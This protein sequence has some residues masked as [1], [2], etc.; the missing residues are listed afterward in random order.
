MTGSTIR[1][2]AP[3]S[4]KPSIEKLNRQS[5]EELSKNKVVRVASLVIALPALV[6]GITLIVLAGVGVLPLLPGLLS[7]IVLA[8][9]S[10]F[11]LVSW[12]KSYPRIERDNKNESKIN[13]WFQKQRKKDL[14]KA[15]KNPALFGENIKDASGHSAKSQTE[16]ILKETKDSYLEEIFEANQELLLFMN[17]VP[18][19]M[20]YVDQS[21]ESC[22]RRVISSYKL[23]KA[24]KPKLESLINDTV[25]FGS[26][27]IL[28]LSSQYQEQGKSEC[29]TKTALVSFTLCF[30][31]DA[32]PILLRAGPRSAL[33]CYL[34]LRRKERAENFFNPQHPCYY[35]RLAFN[36]AIGVYRKLFKISALK[37]M[38]HKNQYDRSNN[39]NL[40]AILSFV[41]TID[42]GDNFLIEHR[43]TE[44]IERGNKVA[45]FCS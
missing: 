7:G 31:R 3:E 18:K 35:A 6:G 28:E 45:I 14:A 4:S 23:I 22:I 5:S 40:Q 8:L 38:Y 2:I 29:R 26:T 42:E 43:N 13:G 27:R 44:Y 20:D 19:T 17:W 9:L 16:N 32:Y 34:Y 11:F 24:C 33:N 25:A 37:K 15:K 21:S 30:S 10:L 41:K 39:E 1:S 12:Y 36:E